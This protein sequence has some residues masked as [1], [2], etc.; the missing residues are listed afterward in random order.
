MMELMATDATTHHHAPPAV[1]SVD[2]IFHFTRNPAAGG[3]PTMLTRQTAIATAA[4]GER[5]AKPSKA[6][7]SSDPA[8]RSTPA[9]T[10]NA[11]RFITAYT[12]RYASS[13]VRPCGSTAIALS[14]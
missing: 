9:S 1:A 12:T 4:T 11:P 8:A 7:T 5:A 6:E 10:A 13:D 2:M 14:R 3:R